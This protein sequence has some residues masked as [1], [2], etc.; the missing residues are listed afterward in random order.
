MQLVGGVAEKKEVGD[1]V[2]RLGSFGVMISAMYF[3]IINLFV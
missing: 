1:G 2:C 3:D